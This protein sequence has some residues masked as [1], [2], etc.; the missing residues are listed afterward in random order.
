[1]NN[2]YRKVKKYNNYQIMNEKLQSKQ[3]NS[4]NR[5]H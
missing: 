1:M 4:V 2:G 3:N 5:N